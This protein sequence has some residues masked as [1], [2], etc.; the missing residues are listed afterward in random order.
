MTACSSFALACAVKMNLNPGDINDPDLSHLFSN[1]LFNT[2]G[3]EYLQWFYNN[4][5]YFWRFSQVTVSRSGTSADFNNTAALGGIPLY[6]VMIDM[7]EIQN[8]IDNM[9]EADKAV[10]QAFR[11]VTNI[12][13]IELAIRA[14]DWQGSMVYSEAI[15]ARYGGNLT[16]KFDTQKELFDLW[17]QQLDESI[18]VL[19]TASSDQVKLG[20]QDFMFKGDWELWARY[21]NSLKLRIA[22]R[23][24]VAD[25]A[26]MKTCLLYTSDAADDLPCVDLGGRR[27]IKKKKKTHRTK[28][29]TSNKHLPASYQ[30]LSIHYSSSPH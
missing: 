27:I 5:V 12:P 30:A 4:S 16:P 17:I 22:A 2:A 8:R 13:V 1:A 24:E 9:P 19:T 14:S 3:D 26:K 18:N 15:D 28:T 11:A 20:N 21:A 29:D 25:N 10:Y 6:K 7:K 23:L